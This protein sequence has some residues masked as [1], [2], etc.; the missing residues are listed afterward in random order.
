[1]IEQRL[2]PLPPDDG[3]ILSGHAEKAGRMLQARESPLAP[4]QT[5]RFFDL[6][7]LKGGRSILSVS[8]RTSLK[9]YSSKAFLS[10]VRY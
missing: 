1:L 6:G 7:K 2:T 3:V 9:R 10:S 4:D 8:D 5:E